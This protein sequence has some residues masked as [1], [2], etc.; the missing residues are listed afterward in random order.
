MGINNETTAPYSDLRLLGCQAGERMS[1]EGA[2]PGEFEEGLKVLR[3]AAKNKAAGLLNVN[4]PVLNFQ[5]I[6]IAL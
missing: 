5:D 6:A 4:D 2:L 1:S 3:A